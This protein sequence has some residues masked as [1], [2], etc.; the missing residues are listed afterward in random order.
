MK[1]KRSWKFSAL[2]AGTTLCLGLYCA[3]KVEVTSKVTANVLGD[4]TRDRQKPEVRDSEVE[5]EDMVMESESRQRLAPPP[6]APSAA[7]VR[8]DRIRVEE[9]KRIRTASRSGEMVRMMPEEAARNMVERGV[10]SRVATSDAEETDRAVTLRENDGKPVYR[11][12]GER[13]LHLFG[14]LPITVPTT[15]DVSADTGEAV[16]QE[17]SLL[18]RVLSVFSF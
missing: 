3:S 13:Q 2:V 4:E 7:A 10:F 14:V 9:E 1:K 12:K 17:T 18:T 15:V 8:Q 11:I 5:K 16:A 6:P